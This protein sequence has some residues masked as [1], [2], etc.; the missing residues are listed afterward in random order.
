MST[1]EVSAAEVAERYGL[2][3]M[4]IRPPLGEYIR[5]VWARRKFVAVL[6]RSKVYAENQN[7]YLGQVWAVLNPL[8]NAL[9][10]VLIFGLILKT[11]RG[12]ENVVAFIVVGTFIYRFFSDSVTGAAKSIPGN[13]KLVRS[14]HFP[15]AVMPLS[16]VG[17]Q[18]VSLGPAVAVMAVL[19]FLSDRFLVHMNE[20]PSWRWL[21]IIPALALLYVFSMGVGFILARIGAAVPDTLNLLPFLLRLGMYASGVLFP[22]SRY[23]PSEFFSTLAQYQP[24]AIYLDLARQAM[25]YEPSIPLDPTKWI[26]GLGWAV[27]FFVI[28]FIIF[29]RA[30][31]RYGR[32]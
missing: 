11:N 19:T 13:I 29:W 5:S 1:S 31:A 2:R 21:L 32:E 16:M 3:R 26:L 7:K 14:L 30:E 25:L 15:R 9:V 10:Y 24:V 18:F 27:A 20:A 8:M 4:G 6:S 17:A 23:I 28:G 22:I 12:V